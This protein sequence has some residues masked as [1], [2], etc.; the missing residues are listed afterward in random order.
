MKRMRHTTQL[1]KIGILAA[2]IGSSYMA[3]EA[4]ELDTLLTPARLV[5][6]LH[7]LG[8][9]APVAF[10]VMMAAAVIISPIPSLPLDL[11]A[12]IAFG[13][14]IGTIYA[15]IGA[16]IGAII[17]FLIGRALGR[18]AISRLLR[19]NVVFCEK[20]SDHHLMGLV[21]LSRLLPIFS[22]DIVSYGA[23]LT[24]MSLR[25]F[26]LAT[27]VGMIPPTFVLT[28]LGG[29]VSSLDGPLILFG[30]AMAVLFLFLPK[31]ILTHHSSWWAQVLQG[32]RPI[33]IPKTEPTTPL[34]EAS[35]TTCP[36]C[37]DTLSSSHVPHAKTQ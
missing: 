27:L 23:G 26:A 21:V 14:I 5:E 29:S 35:P 28:Y 9:L 3:F 37:G 10:I 17:S 22:F 11:A 32:Q 25:A 13:P 15:V 18:E 33:P 8:W 2:F 12:G 19:I 31:L 30:V 7:S 6:Y 20:C 1:V 24:N 16:E 34:R 36:F 4:Y